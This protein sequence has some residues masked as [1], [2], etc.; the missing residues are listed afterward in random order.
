M[1]RL[2]VLIS[3]LLFIGCST[4]QVIPEETGVSD[5]CMNPEGYEYIC[6]NDKEC[7]QYVKGYAGI[8]YE[9]LRSGMYDK[10]DGKQKTTVPINL[11]YDHL[12]MSM[13]GTLSAE[14]KDKGVWLVM[15]AVMYDIECNV[16]YDAKRESY[17]R[18]TFHR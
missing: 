18:W 5:A 14:I 9:R 17:V 6:Y 8:L 10:E 3:A 12:G 15:D 7:N 4:T 13:I 16:L 1:K 11:F 2:V